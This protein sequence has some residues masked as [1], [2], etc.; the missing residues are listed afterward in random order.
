MHDTGVIFSLGGGSTHEEHYVD[1]RSLLSVNPEPI[2]VSR[3]M[4]PMASPIV[5]AVNIFAATLEYRK[6]M[7]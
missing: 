5:T 7:P 3:L 6:T 4:L 1:R 2:L